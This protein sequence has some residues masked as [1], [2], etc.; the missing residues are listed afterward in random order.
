MKSIYSH[1]LIMM[2][3]FGFSACKKEKESF[4]EKLMAGTELME[5]G[6]KTGK[7]QFDVLSNANMMLE[8]DVAWIVLDTTELEKG[9]RKVVFEVQA[10]EDDERSGIITVRIN[11]ELSKQVLVS[12]ESGKVPVFFVSPTGTGDGSSWESPSTFH[13]AM[14]K[15]TTGSTIYMM[16]GTYMPA[17][18][19]RNGESAEESD[20]TFEINKNISV[21]GGFSKDASIGAKP[22]AAMYKTILDGRFASGKQAFHTVT[23]TAA[24]ESGSQVYIEGLVI[25]GGNAT[26]RSTNISINGL[27]FS[28][29]QGGGM[30]IGGSQV[31]L[32]NV[33]IIENK[34]TADKGT[35]GFAAGMYAFG[36]A[37]VIMENSKVNNNTNAGNNGGGVW[38]H[39]SN[40][41]AYHSQFNENSA[42]GTAGGVHGYP[43][44]KII[45]YNSEVSQNSNTS[46]GAGLY[47]REKSTGILVNCLLVGNKSTSKNGGGAVMLYDDCKIDIISSTITGNEIP[48]PGAGVYRRSKVNN[49]TIINSIISGNKQD[50]NSTDV[51]AYT[52][53]AGIIP[54]IKSSAIAGQVYSEGGSVAS[55]LSFNP[56]TML[57][58]QYL[59]IGANNPALTHGLNASSL[60][61]IGQTYSPELEEH[62]KADK[63]GNE[64]TDKI[65]G[66][67]IK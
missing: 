10:N 11:N 20:K 67:L 65:M 9:K 24:K 49:L 28:R 46:Y 45:L 25:T 17:K 29:G 15:A 2:V 23:V 6:S 22:N 1:L 63:N 61:T 18:T 51:D 35:V 59:P 40:L 47:L 38:M 53:N 27:N 7:Y 14:E 5:V 54:V 60:I 62:I 34:A 43:N 44:A 19:I 21:I 30:A 16:E 57:S 3:L 58:A 37:N 36:S 48:G 4:E 64:R 42:R 41:T 32:K 33:E 56:A 66:A 31:H 50:A 52:D 55:G 13:A 8:S 12:Q 39:T 26:D